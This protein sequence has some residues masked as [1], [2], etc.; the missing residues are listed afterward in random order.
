MEATALK[1]ATAVDLK[2]VLRSAQKAT[3]DSKSKTPVLD[4]PPSIKELAEKVRIAK[5]QVE[6]ATTLFEELSANLVNEVSGIRGE[7]CVREYIS[8]VKVPTTSNLMV[9]VTWSGN[10][11]KIKPEQE[12]E[13]VKIVGDDR[14]KDYFRSVYDIAIKKEL[15]MDNNAL[16]RL[17]EWLGGGSSEDEIATGQAR[18][19]QYFE[20]D[21]NIKVT[22]R[23][24]RDHVL[25]SAT[26]KEGLLLAGVKQYKPS[27]R[28]R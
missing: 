13:I 27:V 24:I 28:S 3:T 16:Y 10:Y 12:Q 23:F 1:V 6:K 21:E 25:M 7:L 20:V 18:F 9:A 26:Q 2:S 22:E 5:E 19:H 8:S 4:V 15:A 11:I 14:F 17:F